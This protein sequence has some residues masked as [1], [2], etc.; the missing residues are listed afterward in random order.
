MHCLYNL[1][2]TNTSNSTYG[3]LYVYIILAYELILEFVLTSLCFSSV[4]TSNEGSIL[5]PTAG[6]EGLGDPLAASC[7]RDSS[8]V[9]QSPDVLDPAKDDCFYQLKKDHQRRATIGKIMKD[10][11]QNICATWH[12]KILEG[13][14]DSCITIQHLSQLME[15]LKAFIQPEQSQQNLQATL[16]SLSYA[17]DYDPAKM[18]H[19]H[20]ALYL[21]QDAVNSVLRKHSIKPHWMFALD[22]LA[23]SAVT[24]AIRVLSPDLAPHLGPSPG[25]E[26]RQLSPQPEQDD[27]DNQADS[28]SGVST[29]NSP[30]GG[31]GAGGVGAGHSRVLSRLNRMRE[32]NRLLLTDLLRAQTGYQELLKQSLAE[33]KL[34]LQVN[35][36]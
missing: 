2:N 24:A 31:G 7:R 1:F 33:Q 29:V 12:R 10:D 36:Y 19:L 28:T 15:G 27:I 4:A 25:P 23:R 22:T 21:F 11:K 14:P 16:T 32:E 30:S 20:L 18:N 26:P 3:L 9:L 13:T 8:G 34:H 5:T 6:M 17:L 35:K